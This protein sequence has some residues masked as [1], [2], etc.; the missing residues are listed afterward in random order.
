MDTIGADLLRVAPGAVDVALPYRD[1]LTQQHGYLHAAVVT[2]IV[3]TACG[4]AALS[5]LPAD[6]DVLSIEFKVNFLAPARGCRFVARG[7]VVKPGRR[8]TVCTGDVFAEPEGGGEEQLV[9][10]MLAT[11]TAARHR[12]DAAD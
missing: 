2:A 12:S 4:Y 1:D 9:A 7:R 10:T 5:L 3:D 11:M 8:I 6:S